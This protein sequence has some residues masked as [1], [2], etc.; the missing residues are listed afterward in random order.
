MLFSYFIFCSEARKARKLGFIEE[1]LFK[2]MCQ[3][4]E[5]NELKFKLDRFD[6]LNDIDLIDDSKFLQKQ[7]QQ[8]KKYGAKKCNPEYLKLFVY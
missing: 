4:E 5:K 6:S 1:R 7:K 3:L 8:Q 2:Q